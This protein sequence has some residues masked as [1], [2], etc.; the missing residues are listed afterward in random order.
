[1]V[2]RA[3]LAEGRTLRRGAEAAEHQ[4]IPLAAIEI[5][6]RRAIGAAGEVFRFQS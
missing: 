4:E 6:N 1:L 2:A 3:D 5:G